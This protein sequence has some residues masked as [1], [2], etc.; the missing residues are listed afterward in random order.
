LITNRARKGLAPLPLLT[1]RPDGFTLDSGKNR[2]WGRAGDTI[3]LTH[4]AVHRSPRL[5][6]SGSG[7]HDPAA[8]CS[9]SP[10]EFAPNRRQWSAAPDQYTHTTFSHGVHPLPLKYKPVVRIVLI[11][12]TGTSLP[13]QRPRTPHYSV[14]AC[15]AS[16]WGV[17]PLFS[18]RNACVVLGA[19]Y[20]RAAQRAGG[21]DASAAA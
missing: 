7:R 16:G 8:P 21:D 15:R 11:W 17:G 9:A 14:R 3:A 10:D 12:S 2:Y 4:I 20:P 6:G 18:G 19:C 5:W 13:G 1:Q